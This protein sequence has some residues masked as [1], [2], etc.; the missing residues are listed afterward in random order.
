MAERSRCSKPRSTPYGYRVWPTGKTFACHAW[1]PFE[2]A[3]SHGFHDARTAEW[4]GSD[5]VEE[6]RKAA[7]QHGLVEATAE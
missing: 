4:W 7:E 3:R 1:S 5:A 2:W 6:F